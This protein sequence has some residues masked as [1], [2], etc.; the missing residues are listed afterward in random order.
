M[1]AVGTPVK[2]AAKS[3]AKKSAIA[4]KLEVLTDVTFKTCSRS[5]VSEEVWP[6]RGRGAKRKGRP[7][8]TLA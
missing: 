5:K 8:S 2:K 1:S 7:A 6:A 3:P 4:A